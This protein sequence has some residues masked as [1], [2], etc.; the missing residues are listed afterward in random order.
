M[1]NTKWICIIGA[2]L[3]ITLADETQTERFYRQSNGFQIG[4]NVGGN[5]LNRLRHLVRFPGQA[6]LFSPESR[7]NRFF[8]QGMSQF[9]SYI[10]VMCKKTKKK[11]KNVFSH[12][13]RPIQHITSK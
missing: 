10:T 13:F 5:V 1:L 4:Q 12:S 9:K 7:G 2:L 3:S 6:E 8:P 11:I